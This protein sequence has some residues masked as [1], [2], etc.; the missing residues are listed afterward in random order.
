[1][2][3]IWLPYDKATIVVVG[4]ITGNNASFVKHFYFEG[5]TLG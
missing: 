2:H 5:N 4:G 1:M 3:L